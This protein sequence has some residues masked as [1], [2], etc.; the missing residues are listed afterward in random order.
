VRRLSKVFAAAG[1]ESPEIDARFLVQ[2]IL[3]LDAATVLKDPERM[4]GDYAGALTAAAAR[5]LAGEP[6][7]RILGCRDFYGRTF[8]ITPDVLDPRPDTET[9]INAVV[10]LAK[11]KNW[12]NTPIS[13]ADVGTGSGAILVTLLAE[14]PQA[15]GVG[16]D[17]SAAALDVARHNA[18]RH[19]VAGRASFAETSVLKGLSQD[20]DLVVSN[21]PYI[22]IGDIENLSREVRNYDPR[23]ALD[24]GQDGLD[25]YRQIV[26]DIRLFT[27]STLVILEV[28]AGQHESVSELFASSCK[29]RRFGSPELLKDLGGHLRC[30]ALE[31]HP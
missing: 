18:E 3:Q 27:R 26:R 9:L 21:P 4:A 17:V 30:V 16:T 24:G 14:L 29:V 15:T 8:K 6:V 1:L 2:G 12:N 11:I 10:Q 23:L 28:G 5:R 7:S 13:I 25:I 19:G 31:I 20:F 22:S